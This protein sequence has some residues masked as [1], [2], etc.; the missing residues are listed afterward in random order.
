MAFAALAL[1]VIL[2]KQ[3]G[4]KESGPSIKLEGNYI[5]GRGKIPIH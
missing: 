1:T 3:N 4:D 2:L 5:L